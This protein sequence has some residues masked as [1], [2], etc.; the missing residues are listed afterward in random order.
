MSSDLIGSPGRSTQ[1]GLKPPIQLNVASSSSSPSSSRTRTVTDLV[2]PN[3]SNV[4]ERG[5]MSAP[6]VGRVTVTLMDT[7]WSHWRSALLWWS[8]PQSLARTHSRHRQK[9]DHAP[10]RLPSSVAFAYSKLYGSGL[11]TKRDAPPRSIRAPRRWTGVAG[12]AVLRVDR[13]WWAVFGRA[14]HCLMVEIDLICC[15]T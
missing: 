14:H 15:P 1:L 11:T 3:A 7:P 5:E 4:S 9:A 8:P 10:S 6:T 12:I 13:G 2:S